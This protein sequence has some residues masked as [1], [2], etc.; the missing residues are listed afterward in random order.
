MNRTASIGTAIAL[1]MAAT[2][3][4][5]GASAQS[6]KT[7]AKQ[8]FDAGN[9]L[10]DNED[11]AAATAEFELSVKIFP[12][13]MGLFNLANCYK[14]LTRYGDALAA[15]ARL[16]REFAG[17]LG[18][19]AGEVA[20]LKN[21]IEGMVGRITVK[22]DRD[23]ASVR[24]DGAD[25]G[26]SPL[27]APLV[28]APGDHLVEARLP[29]YLDAAQTVR[30]AARERQELSLALVEEPPP[31]PVV[32]PPPPAP[33]ETAPAAPETAPAA[34]AIVAP[35]PPPPPP[36][37]SPEEL[38]SRKRHR[39]LRA[40]GWASFQVG[41]VFGVA[42]AALYG[43]A[44]RKAEDFADDRR[45]YDAVVEA[46]DADGPSAATARDAATVWREMDD[47]RSVAST[48]QKLG[49]GFGI[50]A[51]ALVAAA[52]ALFVA[53]HEQEKKVDAPA[54]VTATPGG[55]AVEF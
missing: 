4:A 38:A 29:G 6:A 31:P 53:G 2:L 34:P 36:P 50:A 51:G 27:A 14:A 28:L 30:V 52:T 16:E 44:E 40:I 48:C 39:V 8:H 42:S 24:V 21:T 26:A 25:V 55:L 41:V 43:V 13:K 3:L 47:A 12:T 7:E 15:L 23:G 17:K 10:V 33:V 9:A 54:T 19:L 18:S 35:A 22:V 11:Y 20:A 46:L 32:E 1:A 37:L 5:V 45:D 49:L